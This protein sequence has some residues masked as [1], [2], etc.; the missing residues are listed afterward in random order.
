M[1]W[2]DGIGLQSK[3]SKAALAAVIIAVAAAVLIGYS[4]SGGKSLWFDR[5]V[6]S[7]VTG[8]FSASSY[9]LFEFFTWFGDKQGIGLAALIVLAWLWFKKRDYL[10]MAVLVIAVALGNEASKRLK[11]L[12]GRERPELEHITEVNSLSF[13]SGHAMVGGI[14]YLLTAY[15]VIKELKSAGARVMA[16]AA[17]ALW[18]LLIG[19]SRIVLQ[20]HYPTDV[21]GGYAFAFIW[22]YI[23]VIFYVFMNSRFGRTANLRQEE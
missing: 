2:G 16:A 7:A 8:V 23:W 11:E 6:S 14:L 4:V 17:F 21:A 22:V 20:V 19:I 5:A 1:S 10:G 13:P 15:F 18:I 9:P 12:F 3:Q